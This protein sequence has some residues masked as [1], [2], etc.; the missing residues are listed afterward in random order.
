MGT[1]TILPP[2]GGSGWC[3]AASTSQGICS[4]GCKLEGGKESPDLMRGP[5]ISPAIWEPE[6]VLCS[7]GKASPGGAG[8][9]L[10]LHP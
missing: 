1:Q 2:Q 8:V 5:A 10:G 3:L 4:P 9:T 6:M 7:M